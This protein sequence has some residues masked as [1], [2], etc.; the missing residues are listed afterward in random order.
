[1]N[2][3]ELE[4][5][6]D[7][8]ASGSGEAP[9]GHNI[10]GAVNVI[11]NM[12]DPLEEFDSLTFADLSAEDQT[13]VEEAQED[14]QWHMDELGSLLGSFTGNDGSVT[15]DNGTVVDLPLAATAASKTADLPNTS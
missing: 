15:L 12:L 8:L 5:I 7:G 14:L 6:S 3:S 4:R 9:N 11:I 10:V 1:M 13:A 2:K